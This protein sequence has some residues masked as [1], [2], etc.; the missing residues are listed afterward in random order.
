V[1]LG[2]AMV[3]GIAIEL[4][5]GLLPSRYFGWGDLLANALGA[6]LAGLWFPL[7]RYVQYDR[8]GELLE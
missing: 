8:P 7:E 2:A 3:V 1:V 4:L 5:Q 6:A